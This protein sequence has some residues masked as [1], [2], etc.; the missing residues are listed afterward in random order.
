MKNNNQ[1]I[2]IARQYNLTELNRERYSLVA[3]WFTAIDGADI[4]L[5]SVAE[6]GSGAVCADG[7]EHPTAAWLAADDGYNYL[8]G[9]A[10][11]PGFA[12]CVVRRLVEERLPARAPGDRQ[13]ILF[14]SSDAW[15][16]RL[17]ALLAP[18]GGF[19]IRRH[20][21]AFDTVE[22]R[23]ACGTL[24]ALPEGYAIHTPESGR[25]DIGVFAGSEE[26]AHCRAVFSGAGRAEIDVFTAEAHRRRGLALHACTAFID[27]CLAAGVTPHWSCWDYNTPSVT[28]ALRLG[29]R[30]LPDLE[31]NFFDLG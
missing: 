18:H 15:K 9:D 27:R 30:Q 19:R 29:F 4:R 28:L 6:A 3:P 11:A 23:K 5:A 14:S 24:P 20:T 26:A 7:A 10:E 25:F 12:G 8:A 17:D 31:V 22:Y 21:F 2:D 13:G 16:T 1:N